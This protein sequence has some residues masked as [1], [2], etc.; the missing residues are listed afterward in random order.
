[1]ANCVLISAEAC[2]LHEL[3][4]YLPRAL[5]VESIK[6]K[7]YCNNPHTLAESEAKIQ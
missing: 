1:M 5:N 4:T 7:V 6:A 2:G 3:R